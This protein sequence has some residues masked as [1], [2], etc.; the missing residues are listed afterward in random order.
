MLN[1]RY[2]RFSDDRR[3][4]EDSV[5]IH[6]TFVSLTLDKGK[7]TVPY[8]KIRVPSSVHLPLQFLIATFLCHNEW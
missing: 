3:G 8:N 7:I 4:V 6:V 2:D 5:F 1:H